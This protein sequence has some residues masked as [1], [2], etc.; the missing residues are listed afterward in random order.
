MVCRKPPKQIWALG[1]SALAALALTAPAPAAP[2]KKPAAKAPARGKA[3]ASKPAA[4]KAAPKAPAVSPVVSVTVGP[5][6]VLLEGPKARQQLLVTGER[7][8]GTL[9][10]LTHQAK[11]FSKNPKV[12]AMNPG[13]VVR[14]T[15]DGAADL[16]VVA[17]GKRVPVKVTAKGVSQPFTWNFQNHVQSVL[18]KAGC[19]MGACHGAAAGKNGFRLTLRGY[20]SDLDYE[21]LRYESGGRRIQPNDPGNSLLLK[22]ATAAVPH[23]G[24]QRFKVGSWE[25]NVLAGWI[26][27]GMPGPSKE[28]PTLAKLDVLPRERTLS[29]SVEQ[30][31]VVRAH[32][33]DGHVEDV[34]HW[35]RYSSNEEGIATVGEDGNVTTTGVGETQITIMYLGQVSFANVTVPFP[36]DVNPK[37]YQAIPAPSYID[38]LVLSK[39]QKLRILP[40]EL[41]SDEEFL[42]RAYLD[43]IGT[44]PT[45]DEVRAF[46]GDKTPNKRAKLVDQLLERP[47][48]VY[49]WTY[50]W[51]DLLR[52]NRETLTEKGMW[53]FYSWLR[54]AVAENKPWDQ[55]VHEVLTANGSNFEYGPSNFYRISRT[56]EDLTETVSQAFLGI[57][58]QCARCHNHPFEKWTQANY[59]EFANF[60]SRVAR[61]QGDHPSDLFIT[62]AAGGEIN[63]PKTGKPL[64]PTPYDGQPMATDS[65]QDRRVYL[66]DWLASPK[67]EYFV[68]SIVNRIWRHY[69]G[70]GL[71]EP[72]DDLRATNPASNE[73]LMEAL[74]KDL[75][76]HKFDLKHL[77]RQ[78]MNS[79]TYQLT[80]RPRPEN[81]KDDRQYSRYFVKRLT[82]EQLLD[83]ICQVTGQ[84]EKFPGLPAGY[85]AIHLPDTRVSNYFLDV[86]GRPPR[87]ITCDCERAQEP[88]MAQALHL[89][90]GQGVNQKI[91][92]DAGLVATLIKAGKK[93]PEIVEELYLACFGRFPTKPELDQ[94][95]QIVA[96]AMNPPQPEMK[97]ADPKAAPAKP[98]EAPA[99]D[100]AKAAEAKAAEAKPAEMKPAEMKKEEPKLDPAV[101]RRQVLE[102]LLWALI[103]GKEFVFNH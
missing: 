34:T 74:G 16:V 12:A 5:A 88:N 23:A 93:D 39:L 4:A 60:F 53:A 26:A 89:I 68:R 99:A 15:G 37:Q 87:Q 61:K 78:I 25:Y 71:I 102:D 52:V 10:D 92:S 29:P 36:N 69:M 2:A 66:A 1:L 80:S 46:L 27:A 3:A 75:V 28:D 13:G 90:N 44:L 82:A 51:G 6:D 84:P 81:K 97:P 40:S 19:N 14:P 62:A 7:K 98:G 41:A 94:A 59:Y 21:R 101:A 76:E 30:Q 103:N 42:R 65:T 31:L 17:A 38:K 91:S 32:F 11:F 45:P 79:R 48:Y 54:D 63:F 49:F 86:F 55:L 18:S 43:T 56:P 22:K 33:S 73:P 83:A 20:D 35:A 50:K 85:R 57:R 72:V 64:P 58:V 100:A 8:D 24:G 9:V 95:V 70:R 67:N 77:M 47:E 96:E